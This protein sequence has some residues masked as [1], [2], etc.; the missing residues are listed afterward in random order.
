MN[1][2]ERIRGFFAAVL[3]ILALILLI[4]YDPLVLG[5]FGAL[6]NSML[7]KIMLYVAY[8]SIAVMI[9]VPSLF[10][11]KKI[12]GLVILWASF[13]AVWLS[14]VLIKIVIHRPRPFFNTPAALISTSYSSWDFSFPSNHATIA[15]AAI[16]FIP[17]RWK[18]PWVIIASIIALSRVYFGLHYLSDV[19]AGAVIG[20]GIGY[21]IKKKFDK[22]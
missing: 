18:I 4:I 8:S 13:A 10:Y 16:P 21:L 17:K 2:K 14:T 7:D 20:F 6:R 3:M 15:F 5:L 9:I 11:L 19:L 1:Q 22:K 12:K